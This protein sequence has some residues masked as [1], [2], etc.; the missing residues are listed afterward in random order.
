[1]RHIDT[2]TRSSLIKQ[3]DDPVFMAWQDLQRCLQVADGLIN[4]GQGEAA[5]KF[6]RGGREASAK[7]DSS[8]PTSIA[9]ITVKAFRARDFWL[10][11]KV[12]RTLVY[13][14]EK[15]F[16]EGA[17]QTISERWK[18]EIRERVAMAEQE[19]GTNHRATRS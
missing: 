11:E 8:L 4:G 7:L 1:M 16:R 19:A 2:P 17:S 6:I 14:I 3:T 5:E 10:D 9:G 12:A 15:F 18:A 13:R